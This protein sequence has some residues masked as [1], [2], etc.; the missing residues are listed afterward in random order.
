M[1]PLSP[2]YRK[3]GFYLLLAI[4]LILTGSPATAAP[5]TEYNLDRNRAPQE[6]LLSLIFGSAPPLA[7]ERGILVIDAFADLNGN[8]RRDPGEIDLSGL[9]RCS[10]DGIDYTIPAFIPG[11]KYEGNYK[12]SCQGASFQPDLAQPDLFIGR[13]GAIIRLDIPCRKVAGGDIPP[14]LRDPPKTN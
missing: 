9:L 4:V 12:L 7:T 14:L 6:N 13:R 3:S 5:D 8:G 2:F 1:R 11:L 10:L